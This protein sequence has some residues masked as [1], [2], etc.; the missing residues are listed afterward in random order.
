MPPKIKTM[1]TFLNKKITLPLLAAR[2]TQLHREF[3]LSVMT[4][5]RENI[6]ATFCSQRTL[7]IRALFK[8]NEAKVP[9]WTDRQKLVIITH[10]PRNYRHQTSPWLACETLNKTVARHWWINVLND[11]WGC[12]I[13]RCVIIS[14]FQNLFS[15]Q[16]SYEASHW[17]LLLWSIQVSWL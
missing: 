7:F 1:K 3:F 5:F 6:S 16:Q 14:A 9:L 17:R 13:E 11:W 15:V 2:H 12:Y 10:F 8:H 4:S